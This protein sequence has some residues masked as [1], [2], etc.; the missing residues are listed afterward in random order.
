MDNL[1]QEIY[2]KISIIQ[3]RIND[4]K[5]EILDLLDQLPY[6]YIITKTFIKDYDCNNYFISK[7]HKLYF[8]NWTDKF[9][10]NIKNAYLFKSYN[11]AK[12]YLECL[13]ENKDFYQNYIELKIERVIK[14]AIY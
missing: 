5:Q 7:G 11:D 13:K 2:Q 1:E 12:F 3:S 9:G 14:D 10:R 6:Q 8:M 4:A